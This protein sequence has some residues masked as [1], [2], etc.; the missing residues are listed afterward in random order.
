MMLSKKFKFVSL[1][2]L[3]VFLLVGVITVQ[4]AQTT[5]ACGK[6]RNTRY[7]TITG[8]DS[9]GQ[10]STDGEWRHTGSTVVYI[11]LPRFNYPKNKNNK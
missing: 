11:N 6:T 4:A 2:S 3:V 10:Q 5:T 7:S 1:L 9:F 8:D